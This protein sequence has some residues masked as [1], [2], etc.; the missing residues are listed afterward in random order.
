MFNDIR[1]VNERFFSVAL[2]FGA[3]PAVAFCNAATWSEWSYQELADRARK[4]AAYLK[5][6]DVQPGDAVGIVASRYPDTIAT[7]I[8]ILDVGAHYVPLDPAY[9]ERR[10][11]LLC[12]DAGVK[13]ILS[14]VPLSDPQRFP[15]TVH[16]VNGVDCTDTGAPGS[17]ADRTQISAET[18]AYIMFTSGSTG[19]PKGVVAPH[20]AIVRLIDN[21]NFMRLDS[22]RV[23]LSLA[24]LGFD[25]STLEIWGPLLNGGK[26]VLYPDQ[27]L[28]TAS[29]LKAVINTTGVNS[30]W[31]TASLFNSF[32]DQD[33]RSLAGVDEILTGGEAL[34]VPHVCKALAELK[35]TQLINGY[36]PTENTTFTTC[37]R[38]PADFSSVEHRVP[39]GVPVSGTE[40]AIIDE[41]LRQVPDGVEGE[42]I[43][44][45]EGLALGYLNKPALTRERFI[46][47][48]ATNGSAARGYRT[49]DRVVRRVDGLI[50]YLGRFDDQVKIDGHR[51]EPG[52]IER[53]IC[54][55]PGIRECR[56]LVR[57]GPAGQKRIAA[58]VVPIDSA[59]QHDLRHR[60]TEIFPAFMMP[61]YLFLLDA[62]PTNANGKLDKAALPDP[63]EQ[64]AA[65]PIGSGSQEFAAVSKAW[66]EILG[67]RPSSEDLNFFDAGGT[68]L[69]AV[70]LYELLSK[71]FVRE[72]APTF[73]F[74]HTTIRR[75]AEAL[76]PTQR[77]DAHA[78]G[79]EKRH[80]ARDQRTQAI[81][82]NSGPISLPKGAL[83]VVGLAG[84]F[85]GAR[86]V[87]ELWENLCAGR[88][89]VHFFGPDEL[90]PSIPISLRSDPNYVQAKGII[91]DYDK[92]DAGFFNVNPLE[93][94]IMDPQQ[95]IMLELAWSALENAG[96]QPSQFSGLIGVY[97]GMN[98]NRYRSHCL[99]A[100]PE[101]VERFGELNT[102]LANEYEFLATRISYKLN[103]RG[104]SITIGTACSTSLV[105]I[106]QASRALL[107]H[108]CDLALAGG[109]SIT[110]PVNAGYLHLEGGMLSAD[111]H[112]RS[113]DANGTGTTFNDGAGL[114]VLRRLEDAIADGDRIYSV[115]R[116]FAVNNDG[117]D[118]VSFTAPSVNGQAEVIRSALEQADIDP[119][120]IGF[121]EAHGT[122]TPL[123]DPIE[124]AALKKVFAGVKSTGAHCAL[125]SVKSSLGHL[126][127]AA[128]VAG[129]IKGVLS[130]YHGKIPPSLFFESPNPS[131]G[132]DDS[133]FYV[134]VSLE[135]WTTSGHPR[136]AGVSSF[137]VGG[138]NAHVVVEEAPPVEP[139]E[140][141]QL[142]QLLMLSAR[143]KTV[144]DR[145]TENLAAHLESHPKLNLAD[146]AYTLRVGR[147]AFAHRRTLVARDSQDAIALLR[148]GNPARVTTRTMGGAPPNVALMFPG[149]GTQYVAMGRTLYKDHAVFRAVVDRCAEILSPLIGDDLRVTLY[150]MQD[151]VAAAEALRATSLTQPALF[152]IE[153]ALAQF[154][155][156]LG[157]RPT[158]LV[159]HSI[160][161][162]VAATLAGVFSLEDALRLVATRGRLMQ[163]LPAGSM[164]S[165]RMA[166]DKISARLTP[167]LAVA[168]HNGPALVVVSGPTDEVIRLQAALET[169]GVVCRLLQTSHAFHSPMMDPILTPFGEVV[170]GVKLSPPTIPFVSTVTGTWIT[171]EQAVD[172]QYWTRHLRETVRFAP[173]VQVLLE[174]PARIL[175]EVGPRNTLGTLARQQAASRPT[176]P[177]VISSLADDAQSEWDAL[178]QGVGQAW[179]A[180]VPIDWVAF[181]GDERRHR[182][183]LP[184]YPFE[185]QRHWVGPRPERAGNAAPATANEEVVA[186]AFVVPIPVTM[187]PEVPLMNASTTPAP[188]ADRK[189]R[190]IVRLKDMFED[191]SGIEMEGVEPAVTFLELGLDSLTLTQVALQLQRTFSVKV[192]FRQLMQD[193]PNLDSLAE[194]MSGQIPAEAAAVPMAA[195]PAAVRLATIG[196]PGTGAPSSYLQQVVDTQLQLMAQQL[197]LLGGAAGAPTAIAPPVAMSAPSSALGI[198]PALPDEDSPAGPVKYDVNK[199]FGAIAR[200]H[201]TKAESLTP[202][203]RAR[204]DAFIRRYNA[205]TK[206]SKKF[207]QDNRVVM[208]DPRAVTGFK[209]AIKELIYPIVVDKSKG[210]HLWDVDGNEYIDA[211]CGFGPCMFGWQPDFVV[212]ALQEQ[213]TRGFEIGPQHPLQAD[214]A[215][216]I[217]DMTGFDR[218]AF[219]NTGSEAVMGCMRIARTV[220]GRNLIAIFSGSYHGVFDEVI[221]RGT[222]K[223]RSVPAA[224]GIMPS[225]SQ[226]V[227]VLDYGTPES[228][229]ILKSRADELAAIMVEPVQSRRP[230]FQ[231]REFLQELRALTDRSGAVYI[232]DEVVT[233]FR[234]SPGG[235]QEFF[236]IKADIA[237]Y[238]K[239]IGGGLPIGVIAGKAKFMDALDGGFWQYGDDSTPPVGVTYFAG[240]FVR[241]PLALAAAH[242]VLSHLKEKGPALQRDLNERTARFVADLNAFAAEV[243]APIKVKTFASLWRAVWE[244]DQPFG[245]LLFYMMRDR[246]VHLYDGFP[247]FFTTAHTEADFASIAKAFKDS[248]IEL[249]EGG[250]VPGHRAPD[251]LLAL[252]PDAPPTPGARLG[253]DPDGT[254]AWFVPNPDTPG[255]YM[256][257]HT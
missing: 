176:K 137:G 76:K 161:E 79:R 69:D 93:A 129:F 239:V 33:A 81:S 147:T 222:K 98:W 105:A 170:R 77:D 253:R 187:V 168:S 218:A 180:G 2:H 246:G 5:G 237:S 141:S 142:P 198:A 43:A 56:V 90:D 115:V 233:G 149:Q 6:I 207:T 20:R 229:E 97:V 212:K 92:F 100:R 112:C 120:T 146:A 232:F 23:F 13:Q 57:S 148:S 235:A 201:A 12:E 256:K 217:C 95:R 131:L 210:A 103:L 175:L 73:V 184:T 16:A 186:P 192:S 150:E 27:Q 58:Y 70:R 39:I 123:G 83:A 104:P 125:G 244:T 245:D 230:D 9:P 139:S 53:V 36:G 75:Q 227:L 50:D 121:I 211:L 162:F 240:T 220:T 118:K 80:G 167:N 71:R 153:Y 133:P 59:Q 42:L 51:I 250:F 136:R 64:T 122:A 94:Q 159:G 196:A 254:P 183:P 60:L 38:I 213:I 106:A 181:S 157:I 45:G 29:G 88:E 67:Q 152:T 163:N 15:L 130:V 216:L 155:L 169:G 78:D 225:A 24:P 214:V 91:E 224:P 178:L 182:I 128:G 126:I 44:L 14:A 18:P 84:R 243:H 47:I 72:L 238:G 82:V 30:M 154:W 68:S 110:V 28:P 32:I 40:I 223:L 144:L 234:T 85:P 188:T 236:G 10:L 145:A 99:S 190:L 255:K 156:G 55:L 65:A 89:G 195:S 86:D 111:G 241:H 113:F 203:Q 177:V 25:A 4:L 46:E 215:R 138:T 173:A 96:H 21:P 52:E 249:Q 206:T 66:E 116:G 102:A 101:V 17:I 208:A 172:P 62:L 228:L 135:D 226:N 185:R 54:E 194:F 231:P 26:C 200:I 248:L 87:D 31:L 171:S 189:E 22:S 124:V 221:V 132:L 1:L 205:R 202:L 193:L 35:G 108:E 63:F 109:V 74:E 209:P 11:R 140:S 107:N 251:R 114:V 179:A 49:G 197:A 158:A 199:A 61:H 127:H 19:E 257:L 134:N 48:T 204:L 41:Q 117:S 174:D 8:A 34:S 3:H 247:C 143:S 166:A 37:F 119:A 252:D 242:A 151:E 7:M 219:C 160:G 191:V 164:L 165:V